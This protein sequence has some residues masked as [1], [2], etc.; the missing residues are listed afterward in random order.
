MPNTGMFRCPNISKKW[1]S[2]V[3]KLRLQTTVRGIVKLPLTRGGEMVL[4]LS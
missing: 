3:D 4:Y 2:E 1:A